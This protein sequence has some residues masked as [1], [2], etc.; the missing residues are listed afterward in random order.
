MKE[1][2]VPVNSAHYRFLVNERGII[3][4]V[5]LPVKDSTEEV[6]FCRYADNKH[7]P[8]LTV[9]I[10]TSALKC[11][12]RY[13]DTEEIDQLLSSLKGEDKE[14]ATNCLREFHSEILKLMVKYV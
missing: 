7:A 14:L 2:V 13:A 10:K 6:S 1:Y 12:I 5:I 8:L 4:Q 11:F 9:T 3:Q